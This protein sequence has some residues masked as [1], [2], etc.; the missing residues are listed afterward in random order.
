MGYLHVLPSGDSA[1]VTDPI[2]CFPLVS[3][4]PVCD[5][6]WLGDSSLHQ[7]VCVY[8]C[9]CVCVSVFYFTQS[10][11][12]NGLSMSVRQRLC[13]ADVTQD[14]F[15]VEVSACGVARK[16]LQIG[17]PVELPLSELGKCVWA[18]ICASRKGRCCR[19]I[20]K[21]NPLQRWVG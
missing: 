1:V 17:A 16:S 7:N 3:F 8:V 4:A 15:R 9:V 12:D 14:F 11:S 5:S 20:E 19:I 13:I 10:L 6:V 21:D 18:G 2:V